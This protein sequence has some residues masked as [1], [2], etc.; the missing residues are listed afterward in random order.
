[1]RLDINSQIYALIFRFCACLLVCTEAFAGANP[2]GNAEL[3]KQT[4]SCPGCDLSD[5][6]LGNVD[7]GGADLRNANLSGVA[8]GNVKLRGA[9]LEGANLSGG[10]FFRV[11]FTGANTKGIKRNGALFFLCKGL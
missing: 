11:D 6:S 3:L 4:R 5:I 2:H 10:V 7:L 9:N 1:M 8:L